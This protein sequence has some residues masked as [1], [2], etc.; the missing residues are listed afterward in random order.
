MVSRISTCALSIPISSMEYGSLTERVYPQRFVALEQNPSITHRCRIESFGNEGPIYEPMQQV[1]GS[2][3]PCGVT[4]G[5][6]D[7]LL[8]AGVVFLG[9]DCGVGREERTQMLLKEPYCFRGG[10]SH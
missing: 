6:Q 9:M 5:V 8:L 1:K 4:T 3:I 7:G 2:W 10:Y